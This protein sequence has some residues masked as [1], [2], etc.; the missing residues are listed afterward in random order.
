MQREVVTGYFAYPVSEAKQALRFYAEHS[1]KMPDEMGMGAGIGNRPGQDPSLGIYF[2]WSGD[3]ADV[4]KHVAP[5]RKAGTVVRENIQTQDYVAV[6]RSGDVDDTRV[7]TGQ[8]KSGFVNDVD[9]KLIDHV[10]DNFE[11]HPDRGTR[12]GFSQ[13]GGAISRVGRTDTAFSH[14]EAQHTLMSF[15]SWAPGVDGT[16]HAKYHNAHWSKVE[17]LTTGFYVND[18]FD[19]SQEQV[20]QTYRE[21]FPRLLKIKQQYDSTN[22][23]RLNANI[24]TA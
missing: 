13:S 19:Q 5:L 14:R 22:L 12:V 23:F 21:N 11:M 24:T 20:N 8:M 9:D 10:M 4:E 17:P 1:A 16:E 18:Y 3:P 2:I 15:V 6:Q 7:F